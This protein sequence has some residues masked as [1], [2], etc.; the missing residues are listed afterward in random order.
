MDKTHKEQVLAILDYWKTIEF[1]EQDD[2]PKVSNNK[3]DGN[4][5]KAETKIV[6]REISLEIVM[7]NVVNSKLLSKFSDV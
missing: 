5:S 4:A 1:L 7:Q 2:L 3:D 6:T